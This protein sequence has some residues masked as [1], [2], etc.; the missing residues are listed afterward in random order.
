MM[1]RFSISSVRGGLED[2][3]G[4]LPQLVPFLDFELSPTRTVNRRA[5]C[6]APSVR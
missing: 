3:A 4:L 1:M 2:P 6:S 5:G